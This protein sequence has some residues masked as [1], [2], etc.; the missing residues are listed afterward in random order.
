M[1]IS[2]LQATSNTLLSY[3]N[4]LTNP[5]TL[6][7]NIFNVSGIS[8]FNNIAN[9]SK[10]LIGTDVYNYEDSGLEVNKRL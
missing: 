6:H 9:M 8:I 7:V 3:I 1:N 10:T 4:D 2:N 5:S